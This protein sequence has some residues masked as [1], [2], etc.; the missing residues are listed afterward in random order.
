MQSITTLSDLGFIAVNGSARAGE[1]K[2]V[3]R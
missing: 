3:L 1:E 2:I